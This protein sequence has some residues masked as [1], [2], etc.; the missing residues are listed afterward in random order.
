M[1]MTIENRSVVWLEVRADSV[2]AI[3]RRANEVR[4]VRDVRGRSFGLSPSQ[5]YPRSPAARDENLARHSSNLVTRAGT[6]RPTAGPS[7]N[8]QQRWSPHTQMV[9]SH[10][11]LRHL[12]SKSGSAPVA[13]AAEPAADWPA[14]AARR[15]RWAELLRRVF[16][17][18]VEGCPRCGGEARIVAFITEP[19]VVR[20]ILAHLERRGVEARTGPWAAAAGAPG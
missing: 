2:P 4:A 8:W 17:V 9:P 16:Q 19:A 11:R 14:L 13:A 1:A 10:L 12:C 5:V 7:P 3:R 20:R 6:W 18:E 15:R